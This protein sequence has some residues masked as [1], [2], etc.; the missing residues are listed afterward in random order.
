MQVFS[1]SY[2]LPPQEQRST[3]KNSDFKQCGDVAK[4]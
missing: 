3:H 4:P 1:V 2:F